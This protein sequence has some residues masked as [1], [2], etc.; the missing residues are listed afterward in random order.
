MRLMLFLSKNKVNKTHLETIFSCNQSQVI[1]RLCCDV[2]LIGRVSSIPFSD[3]VS[4]IWLTQKNIFEDPS[5]IL[6]V[7]SPNVAHTRELDLFPHYTL[8]LTT[9]KSLLYFSSANYW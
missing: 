5:H 7:D 8:E 9:A 1:K 4:E 3:L 2:L 6:H